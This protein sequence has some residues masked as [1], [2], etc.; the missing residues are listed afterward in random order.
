[1]YIDQFSI[2]GF[3]QLT[4]VSLDN[5]QPGLSIF[6]GNN[7]A[8]KSTCVE[9]IRSMLTGI[10]KTRDIQ[11]QIIRGS[12]GGS[13]VLKTQNE[14]S[15]TLS[16]SFS[17][18][19]HALKLFDVFGNQVDEKVLMELMGNVDRELYSSIFGFSL[20]ELQNFQNLT[21]D[22]ILDTLYGASLGL[23]L[24]APLAALKE[25][26]GQIDQLYKP[27][28]KNAILNELF[29]RWSLKDEKITVAGQE[30]GLY[31]TL[32]TQEAIL[33]EELQDIRNNEEEISIHQRFILRKLDRWTFWKSLHDVQNSLNLL[34]LL[35]LSFPDKASEKMNIQQ[36]K[37]QNITQQIKQIEARKDHITHALAQNPVDDSVLNHAGQI[38]ELDDLYA[39]IQTEL[40]SLPQLQTQYEEIQLQQKN[41]L[42]TFNETE[43]SI[44]EINFPDADLLSGLELKL[45]E[46]STEEK[47]T[48]GIFDYSVEA[49][50]KIQTELEQAR[51]ILS[52]ESAHLKMLTS[53]ETENLLIHLSKTEEA[54]KI[55]VLQQE[56]I[57][58]IE[59]QLSNSFKNLPYDSTNKDFSPTNEILLSILGEKDK[60]IISANLWQDSFTQEPGLSKELTKLE[61][62][63]ILLSQKYDSV[64][65]QILLSESSSAEEIE[66]IK[67]ACK[68]L[69]SNTGLLA[70]EFSKF[71]GI[72]STYESM[73]AHSERNKKTKAPLI[74]AIL[75]TTIGTSLLALRLI[76]GQ[77]L[78]DLQA[79][80]SFID[81]SSL[82]PT[83]SGIISIPLWAPI[84]ILAAAAFSF[85]L[86]V[87][88]RAKNLGE[89]P[90]AIKQ[91]LKECQQ[92]L[93]KLSANVKEASITLGLPT[94]L[95]LSENSTKDLDA[96]DYDEISSFALEKE[97]LYHARVAREQ[98]LIKTKEQL[99]NLEQTIN[100]LKEQY[101]EIEQNLALH[102]E[103]WEKY[104]QDSNFL[105][106]PAPSDAQMFFYRLEAT[107][108]ICETLKA[109]YEKVENDAEVFS[110]FFAMCKPYSENIDVYDRPITIEDLFQHIR[111]LLD[112]NKQAQA[113]KEKKVFTL[114]SIQLLEENL[115][116]QKDKMEETKQIR[117]KVQQALNE[118]K[119]AWEN[120]LNESGL[121]PS[122]DPQQLHIFLDT[123]AKYRDLQEEHDTLKSKLDI[124]FAQKET[125]LNA[126]HTLLENMKLPLPQ[127]NNYPALLNALIIKER[128]NTEKNIQKQE[129]EK[130]EQDCLQELQVVR[131]KLAIE[132]DA[133]KT[134]YTQAQ[135]QTSE[136]YFALAE[137]QE[138]RLLLAQ[139]QT[140]LQQNLQNFDNL[141]EEVENGIFREIL[142]AEPSVSKNLAQFSKLASKQSPE[143][144]PEQVKNELEKDL[145]LLTT[146]IKLVQDKKDLLTQD[147]ATLR[148][149]CDNLAQSQTLS[150]LQEE[151]AQI[152]TDIVK[153]H[154]KWS[155]L[156]LAHAILMESQNM[157]EKERQP[158]V[159]QRA[160]LIFAD[161]TDGMW[162]HLNIS[163]ETKIPRVLPSQGEP[164]SAQLLSR[165]AQEQ[166]Y[167]SLRIAYIQYRAKSH[168]A[169]P[170]LMD[171]ILVNFDTARAQ[172]TIQVLKDLVNGKDEVPAHQIFYYT[173]HPTTVELLQSIIPQASIYKVENR[174]ISLLS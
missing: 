39:S 70:Q 7:E 90:D 131:A 104:F 81:F 144:L 76:A 97:R 125:F 114:Q 86:L 145:A 48:L 113:E 50:N 43:D 1:M 117:E 68:S 34:P 161:I 150:I 69:Q 11:T 167:L 40:N 19:A 77:N 170:L 64:Q 52:Q 30:F 60:A 130:Q 53:D 14:T 160:S 33:Q 3:G 99:A 124:A 85:Y 79:I 147:I 134:L 148:T 116:H 151:Q 102:T 122:L 146:E 5:I 172:R 166:L 35:E 84:A 112:S 165:G 158:E 168:E 65:E 128:Q 118:S 132:T 149:Q 51:E 66:E 13:L 163:H 17:V 58:N 6:L 140:D 98:E 173:C 159:L 105:P 67:L 8:G 88:P 123:L 45:Q 95:S 75:C 15:Y 26:E 4:N 107:C 37:E 157:Y 46:L 92:N 153:Y 96:L 169:L 93:S 72:S 44:N 2:Q 137:I 87:F 121:N 23:N 154:K 101:A 16:R 142:K 127:D 83:W 80:Q 119:L 135:A 100:T 61:D 49:Y 129:L 152:E 38:R 120:L 12:L 21:T 41:I 109:L 36:G 54:Y 115:L 108:H 89:N 138:K 22:G 174:Q 106:I 25:I 82:T 9:F 156:V 10:P 28:G 29:N 155:Q 110:S 162:E 136:E 55:T 164:F 111:A 103:E 63:K 126:L 27:R 74:P 24:K 56:Q 143:Q 141:T 62:E 133:I 171:D 139:R 18:N 91:V 73:K 71:D 32:Q 20:T 57:K 94:P 31:Q 42:D 47:T 78:V 59:E